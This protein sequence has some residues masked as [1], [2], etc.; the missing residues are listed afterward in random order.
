MMQDG[1]EGIEE[2]WIVYRHGLAPFQ[3]EASA[4]GSRSHEA[5]NGR[6][7]HGEG[8]VPGREVAANGRPT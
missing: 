5:V 8:R 4:A 7:T 1:E 3:S 6:P 2:V